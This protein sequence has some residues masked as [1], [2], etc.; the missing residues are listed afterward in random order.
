[1]V[2][3]I[4]EYAVLSS[5]EKR[6]VKKEELERL[7]KSQLDLME[8]DPNEIR[9]VITSTINTAIDKKFDQF[10]RD[11]RED[12]NKLETENS[13]LRKAI[14]EQQK[15]LEN[16]YR[17]K[18]RSHIFMSGIPNELIINGQK[19]NEP[20]T[21]IENIIHTVAPEVDEGD[22]SIVK[23]FKCREGLTRHSA[24]ILCNNTEAKG[25][26]MKNSK[27]LNQLK[28]EDPLRKVFIKHETSPLHR[29]ENDRIYT[30]LKKLKEEHSNRVYKIFKGKLYEDEEQID[31]FN[32]NN[33][34]FV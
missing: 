14:I 22:Y 13:I 6:R 2:L 26:I 18:V 15:F 34:I 7:I 28:A 24:K 12:Y 31:E 29:K 27:K 5:D 16:L 19:I 23:S 1:M 20:N 4:E 21:I 17:E 10:A 11:I 9:N 25:L 33:S 8:N 30:K 32:I 3:T